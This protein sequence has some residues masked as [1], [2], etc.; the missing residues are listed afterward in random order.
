MTTALEIEKLLDDYRVWLKD[1]T[2]LREVNSKWVEIT[3]PYLDRHNDA[4]QIYARAENGGYVLTDD[5]YTIHDLEAS[6]C[7]LST[8]KR[9]DLLKMTLNGFGVRINREALEVQASPDNFPARKHN[10]IQA[11]LA[12]NDLFYLAQ[13]V[14]ESLF[15]EDVISWLDDNGIRYTPKVKFTGISGFDHLFDFVIPKSANKQPERI[16][17]AINRPTRDTAEAFIYKWGDTREVRLPDSKAYA[18]LNDFEQSIS[19]GVLDAFRNYQIHPVPWSQR[20]DVVPELA[21]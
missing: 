15:F 6:G 14:V 10:L 12:V 9:Q 5:S 18:V 1:K 19:A 2:T 21:A 20:G 7:S 3:T 13:P 17:Q 8:E 16:V 4:L 11:I